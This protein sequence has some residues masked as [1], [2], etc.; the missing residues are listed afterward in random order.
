MLTRRL[1][2]QGG[3]LDVQVAT[4]E[5]RKHGGA[6]VLAIVCGP[7]HLGQR[8]EAVAIGV[9]HERRVRRTEAGR[10]QARRLQR[11]PRRARAPRQL[12]PD[13]PILVNALKCI[14]LCLGGCM[15]ACLCA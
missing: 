3:A 10:V 6:G 2:L 4:E 9:V 1:A 13:T 5:E 12:R 11:P 15:C 14:G 8:R 7:H